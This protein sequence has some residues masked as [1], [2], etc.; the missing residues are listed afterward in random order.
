MKRCYLGAGIL[1][2][3]LVFGFF[4]SRWM[5]D[6][7]ARMEEAL[8]EAAR[9]S[10]EE[11]LALAEQAKAAW[12]RSLTAVLADHQYLERAEL[13]FDLL[14]EAARRGDGAECARLCLE[15][16]RI[17]RT[18]GEDQRLKWENLL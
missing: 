18:L 7:Q 12:N 10:P 5:A 14:A 9:Q 17:F 2:A 4:G 15:L 16:A 8:L 6:H 1:L 3:L 13:A 11:A